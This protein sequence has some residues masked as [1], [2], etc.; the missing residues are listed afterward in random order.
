MTFKEGWSIY[1]PVEEK[2]RSSQILKRA[3]ELAK[4][5]TQLVKKGKIIPFRPRRKPEDDNQQ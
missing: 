1:V 5:R 2:D 4:L 3:A